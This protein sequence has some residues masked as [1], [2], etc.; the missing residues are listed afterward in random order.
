M[1]KRGQFDY[2]SVSCVVGT[3]CTLSRNIVETPG[4]HIDLIT[5]ATLLLL[6][7]LF[8]SSLQF[9][10]QK[11]ERFFIR[12]FP[13]FFLFLY[14]TCY[15]AGDEREIADSHFFLTREAFTTGAPGRPA[16]KQTTKDSCLIYIYIFFVCCC[17]PIR[18]RGRR[19][20]RV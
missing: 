4:V 7:L 2:V 18:R 3:T 14:R 11:V 6:F 20:R 9:N 16:N 10:T 8:A 13:L 17:R 5:H 12:S 1:G 15:S 19:G